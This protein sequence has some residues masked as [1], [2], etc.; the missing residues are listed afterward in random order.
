[1]APLSYMEVTQRALIT[2]GISHGIHLSREADTY[3]VTLYL[4]RREGFV[5][6]SK[7]CRDCAVNNVSE[8]VYNFLDKVQLLPIGTPIPGKSN[9]CVAVNET[10]TERV[11]KFGLHLELS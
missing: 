1:M 11:C 5:G 4:L 6:N 2:L 7:Y 10:A 3:T 9:V 8:N